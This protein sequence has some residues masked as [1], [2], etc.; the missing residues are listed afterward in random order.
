MT[1]CFNLIAISNG[2]MHQLVHWRLEQLVEL[3]L[4]CHSQS[5]NNREDNHVDFPALMD[6]SYKQAYLAGTVLKDVLH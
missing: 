2:I 5:T 1:Y 3:Y 6:L 4:I